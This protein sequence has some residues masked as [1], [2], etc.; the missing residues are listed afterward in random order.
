MCLSCR[1][2]PLFPFRWL[3]LA[4]TPSWCNPRARVLYPARS[5]SCLSSVRRRPEALERRH[6]GVMSLL[7]SSCR[8]RASLARTQRQLGATC[9][10]R[11]RLT[12]SVPFF[13][14]LRLSPS[15]FF[16]VSF[17]STIGTRDGRRRTDRRCS[18]WK[19]GRMSARAAT[20]DIHED[21]RI[22]MCHLHS[23]ISLFHL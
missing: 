21:D 17:P 18:G 13:P 5:S 15:S 10:S 3:A 19:S 7:T 20:L 12:F 14:F 9:R 6:G 16:L 4:L 1:L 8:I 22:G 11:V 2:P 23:F